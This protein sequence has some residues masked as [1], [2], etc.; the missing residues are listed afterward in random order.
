MVNQNFPRN[1]KSFKK[2]EPLS[3]KLTSGGSVVASLWSGLSGGI[4]LHKKLSFYPL[5]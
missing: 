2:S 4:I 5:R 1:R 3:M